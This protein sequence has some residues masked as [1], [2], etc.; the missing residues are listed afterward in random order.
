MTELQ[1]LDARHA[2]RRRGQFDRLVAPRELIRAAS[3]D[4]LRRIGRRHLH[5]P[6][7]ERPQDRDER[8]ARWRTARA[9]GLLAGDVQRVGGHAEE[10][11]RLVVLVRCGEKSHEPCR[12][13]ACERQHAGRERIER[14]RVADPLLAENPARVGHDVVRRQAFGL[15]DDE[16]AIHQPAAGCRLPAVT[17]AARSLPVKSTFS[18]GSAPVALQPEAFL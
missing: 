6:A 14:A 4:L 3:A 10:D 9:A 7:F 12:A 8:V 13:A 2:D 17:I 11:R 1:Q 5:L 15:V 18:T 16:D